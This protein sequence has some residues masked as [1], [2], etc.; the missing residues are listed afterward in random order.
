[1][2]ASVPLSTTLH[3]GRHFLGTF[4]LLEVACTGRSSGG[5][6]I[7][8]AVEKTIPQASSKQT[9]DRALCDPHSS[10]TTRETN[11]FFF[12]LPLAAPL[13]ILHSSSSEFRI[14]RV[15]E[16]SAP[17]AH[18]LSIFPLVF[19]GISTGNPSLSFQTIIA[20]RRRTRY[21]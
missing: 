12:W 10:G 5:S 2:F 7:W 16:K 14:S 9:L 1:M 8:K 18:C 17:G 6:R 13:R 11:M 21:L 19:S 15:S 3:E 20:C 4:R